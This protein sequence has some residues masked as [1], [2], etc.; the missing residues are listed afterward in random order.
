MPTPENS[1]ALLAEAKRRVQ[2][3]THTLTDEQWHTWLAS[4]HTAARSSCNSMVAART[5]RHRTFD[6]VSR[7]RKQP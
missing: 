1:V 4:A 2:R 6:P 3:S 5:T 7:S